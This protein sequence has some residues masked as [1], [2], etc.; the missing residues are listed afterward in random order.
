MEYKKE[1]IHESKRDV[2]IISI[3]WDNVFGASHGIYNG[4]HSIN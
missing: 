2:A 1:V 4:C 3:I